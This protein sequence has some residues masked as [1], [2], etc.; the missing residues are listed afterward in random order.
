MNTALSLGRATVCSP[1]P[2]AHPPGVWV[3]RLPDSAPTPM[4]T[5]SPD[6]QMLA[7][8]KKLV[9]W[10]RRRTTSVCLFCPSTPGPAKITSC[11][12]STEAP[13][14]LTKHFVANARLY[15]AAVAQQGMRSCP[16]KAA[17]TGIRSANLR[18]WGGKD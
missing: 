18:D 8:E 5:Q 12:T 14:G 7:F 9:T 3:R 4:T 13:P 6:P 17:V 16:I 15:V 1:G 2:Q 11:S 10:R